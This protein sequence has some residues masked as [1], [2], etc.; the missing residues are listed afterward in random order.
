MNAV[1][2]PKS[3]APLPRFP[4]RLRCK[5]PFMY[6]VIILVCLFAAPAWAQTSAAHDI[7]PEKQ[8]SLAEQASAAKTEQA[9]KAKVVLDND[10]LERKP[11]QSIPD[12]GSPDLEVNTV[13]DKIVEYKN[14]HPADD[15]K[16]VINGWFRDQKS[17]ID[18][19]NQQEKLYF[20]FQNR[21]AAASTDWEVRNHASTADNFRSAADNRALD[22]LWKLRDLLRGQYGKVHDRSLS[23]GI[24][25]AWIPKEP[26]EE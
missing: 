16:Q 7:L 4:D 24:P 3:L 17:R 10:T 22:D 6:R 13:V 15:A 2:V 23:R 5:S 25:Q 19:L 12:L 21:S 14:T 18:K 11:K 8:P 1:W 20:E 26:G 9:T